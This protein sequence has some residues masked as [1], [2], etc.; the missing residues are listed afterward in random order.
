MEL[1]MFAMILGLECPQNDDIPSK[2]SQGTETKVSLVGRFQIKSHTNTCTHSLLPDSESIVIPVW[3][4]IIQP[5]DVEPIRVLL[6]F[7][8]YNSLRRPKDKPEICESLGARREISV[9]IDCS[10]KEDQNDQT[11]LKRRYNFL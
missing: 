10:R 7:L 9:G 1:T 11:K 2:D 6:V 8:G 4:L 5:S 3:R